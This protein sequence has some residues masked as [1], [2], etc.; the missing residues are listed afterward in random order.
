MSDIFSS[1]DDR[2][3]GAASLAQVYKATLKSTGETVAVKVQHPRV[4][5]HSVVDMATMEVRIISLSHIFCISTLIHT[6]LKS[7]RMFISLI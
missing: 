1:F 4:K 3:H 2:P 6:L 7:N 5:P